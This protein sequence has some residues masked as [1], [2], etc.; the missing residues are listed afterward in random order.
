MIDKK[1]NPIVCEI[2]EQME[3]AKNYLRVRFGEQQLIVE[4]F[5][6]GVKKS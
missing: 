6:K 1:E 4:V 3:G 2:E 5:L